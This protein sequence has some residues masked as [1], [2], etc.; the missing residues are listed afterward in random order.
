MV[1]EILRREM[2][3]GILGNLSAPGSFPSHAVL[4][5][6]Y[7]GITA[8]IERFQERRWS[9]TFSPRALELKKTV[10]DKK[11]RGKAFGFVFF[12]QYL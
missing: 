8:R 9:F 7:T 6:S 11:K 10:K 4:T 1:Q 2:T 5:L 3:T 12:S